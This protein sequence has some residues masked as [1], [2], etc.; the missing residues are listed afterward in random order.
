[1]EKAD[2]WLECLTIF[3][4]GFRSQLVAS[5]S[6]YLE[7]CQLLAVPLHV[8]GPPDSGSGLRMLWV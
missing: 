5:I 6:C 7:W 1:M 2:F 3:A 8:G 4:T